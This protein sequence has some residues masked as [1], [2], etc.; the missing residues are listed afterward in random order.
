MA[1]LYDV[2]ETVGAKVWKGF[3]YGT[4]NDA[5]LQVRIGKRAGKELSSRSLIFIFYFRLT[6]LK[7]LKN[8]YGIMSKRMT[9]PG[10]FS[11]IVSVYL[12]VD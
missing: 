4:H 5:C 10:R 8:L 11:Y 7:P 1:K 12:D 6:T 2:A 9:V 3:D